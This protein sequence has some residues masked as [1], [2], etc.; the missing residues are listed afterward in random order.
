MKIKNLCVEFLVVFAITF[1]VT[2]IVTYLWNL[3]VHGAGIFEWETAVRFALIFGIVL[4]WIRVRENK[5]KKFK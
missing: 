5:R 4:P 3:I 2:I 1:M